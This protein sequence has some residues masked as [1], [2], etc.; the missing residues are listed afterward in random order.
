[1]HL[2]DLFGFVVGLFMLLLFGALVPTIR[3]LWNFGGGVRCPLYFF[4]FF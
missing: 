3:T 4:E 1:M 2:V